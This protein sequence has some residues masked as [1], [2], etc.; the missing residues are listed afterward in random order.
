MNEILVLCAGNICRSPAASA[1]LNERLSRAGLNDVRVRSASLLG[2]DGQPASE[3]S[4]QLMDERDVD[5]R[6]HRSRPVSNHDLNRADLIFVM[7]EEHRAQIFRRSPQ[8]MHKVLLWSELAN[9]Q[10]DIADPY[11]QSEAVYREVFT[12][13][14]YYLNTGWSK[15]SNNL[16]IV[17]V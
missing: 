12:Q 16:R 10:A 17:Y 1:L 14:E 7:E 11:G 6:S 2:L 13:I 15:L 9:T 3:L 4:I 5:L 8:N